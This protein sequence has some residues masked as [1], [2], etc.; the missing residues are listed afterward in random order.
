MEIEPMTFRTLVG[1]STTE[2]RE[3]LWGA[4]SQYWVIIHGL[5]IY[6][7]NFYSRHVLTLSQCHLQ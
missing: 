5:Q 2:P 4:R 6:E 3:L 7:Y 1:R